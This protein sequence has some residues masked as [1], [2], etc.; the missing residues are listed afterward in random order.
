VDEALK[1]VRVSANAA[2]ERA[3]KSE[4]CNLSGVAEAGLEDGGAVLEGSVQL[5]DVAEEVAPMISVCVP[6]DAPLGPMER[7]SRTSSSSS[8]REARPRSPRWRDSIGAAVLVERIGAGGQSGE[9]AVVLVEGFEDGA[10]GADG[11]AV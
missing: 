9:R 7:M 10:E 8:R 3:R 11:G 4:C 2:P 5:G 6:I 1:L